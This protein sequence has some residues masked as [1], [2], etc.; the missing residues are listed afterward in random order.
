MNFFAWFWLLAIVTSV[1]YALLMVWFMV[2]WKNIETYIPKKQSFNTKVAVL[3]P[4]RNEEK[5]LPSCISGLI[6]QQIQTQQFQ[7]FA[8]NDHSTD[9]SVQI[10]EQLARTTDR[11]KL[12]HNSGEGKKAALSFA[13]EQIQ[14]DLIV[15][16]D[17]DCQHNPYWLAT[18]VGY[19]ETYKPSLLIGP[20][21]LL[22]REGFLQKFQQ[23]EFNSLIM[24]TAG[25]AGIGH[26]ILCNGA[27][28]AFTKEAYT[29]L[30]D[31]F[32]AEFASGD[33]VFLLHNFKRDSNNE[34]H[35]IKAE[36][37]FVTT[38]PV[39]TV[40]GFIKQR[41]RWASK[42]KGY[43]DSDALF[44]A[45]IVWLTSVL[46]PLGI[47]LMIK[48]IDFYKPV[49]FVLGAKTLMDALFFTL[50]NPFFKHRELMKYLV[51]FEPI[52]AA[53]VTYTSV[54]SFLAAR[55]KPA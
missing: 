38:L 18:M 26:P 50:T 44:T 23:L 24:S 36:N 47:I 21:S 52:Y 29:K 19:Y 17:A 39:K 45:G 31:P 28:L 41:K 1:L 7:I 14:A 8:I 55:T 40:R 6:K 54:I 12:L 51:A 34:I 3:V 43:S 16:T 22:K 25:A 27:N 20:V 53:Y 32:N 46:M 2:G 35:F 42:T 15:V 5:N 49:L 13:L 10:V 48:D 4:F 37:A 9:R 33:D 11:L 30:D